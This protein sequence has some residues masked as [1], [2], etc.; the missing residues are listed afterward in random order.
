MFLAFRCMLAYVM[1]GLDK[2]KSP[3]WRDGTRLLQIYRD[4]NHRFPWI[5]NLM[6]RRL[7]LAAA[8]AW[9]VT[10]LELLFPLCLVLPPAGFWI[11]IAGGL[12]FHAMIAF[13]MGLHGFWWGFTATYPGVYFAHACIV[14]WLGSSSG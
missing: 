9:S 5:G 14:A 1:A 4:G 8:G 7:V 10:L 6:H 11:F 13:T 3:L 2:L 12:L